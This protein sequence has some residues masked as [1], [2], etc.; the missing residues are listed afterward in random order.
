MLMKPLC[1]LTDVSLGTRLRGVSLAIPDGVTAVLGP[2]GAGKTSLLNLI[3]GYERADRGDV[4]FIRVPPPGR[5]PV[6]WVPQDGG[7]WPHLT[8]RRHLEAAAGGDRRNTAFVDE[9]L[10]DFDLAPRAAALPGTLSQGE[11]ARLSVAR[12]LAASP[13]VA[14][15]DEPLAHVD[16]AREG[17]YW[18]AV[19]RR[20][21]DSGA[22]LIFATHA[23]RTVLREASHVICIQAGEVLF[24]GGVRDLYE[25]P[26]SR[27]A[28]ECLGDAN[29]LTPDEAQRWLG[30]TEPAPRCVRPERLDLTP[31]GASALVV[32]SHRPQGPVS[33]TG[34]RHEPTGLRRVFCHRTPAAPPPAGARVALKALFT[35]LLCG[36]LGLASGCAV[37]DAERALDF[38][39][40]RT[41]PFPPDGAV[42]PAPRSAAVGPSGEVVVIDTAAR[43][44]VYGPD[45]AL[46]RQWRM[47]EWSVGRPEGVCVM[48]DGR[49]VVCDTHYHRVMIFGADGTRLAMFG[50]EGTAPGEFI[51]PV[52]VT[53]DDRN[54]LYVAEYGSN[55]RIQKFTADGTFVLAFGGFGTRPGQFQRPSGLAWHAGRVYAADA[56]NNRLQVFCDDGRFEGVLDD[57]AH[58]LDLRF[59][60]DLSLGPEGALYVIEYG[61]GRL[62]K[63]ALDGRLLGRF[64]TSGSGEGQFATPWGLA[65]NAQGGVLVADTGNRRLVELAP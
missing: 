43:V 38:T 28:A 41:W 33:E 15:M 12:A 1:T 2:S 21:A 24:A 17:R 46:R 56:F 64:G 53:H 3:V 50:R 40:I 5:L 8:V 6:F 20:L 9:L 61:A 54:H 57:P 27:V 36:A 13:A 19:R 32:E 10:G 42:Q 48:P 31:D 26:P 37:R 52:A 7:L 16:P 44:L 65:V 47:P 39:S 25:R 29:W 49:I 63:V 58:P 11:Q 30:R 62:T 55:D 23:P 4:R 60:Y 22:A 59:P 51:Y 18:A 14:V 34:L 45:G 35:A